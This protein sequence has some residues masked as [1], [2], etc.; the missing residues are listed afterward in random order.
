MPS[1]LT[2][3]L[4]TLRR[5]PGLNGVAVL[6]LAAA[7]GLSTAAFTVIRGAFFSLLPAPHAD[8]LVMVHEYHRLGRYNVPMSGSELK[9]ES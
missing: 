3:A 1:V 9:A 2:F 5:A 7:I 8:R 4:R 6:C